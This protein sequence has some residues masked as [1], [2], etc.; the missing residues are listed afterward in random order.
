MSKKEMEKGRCWRKM[1]SVETYMR[2]DEAL[3]PQN[4]QENGFD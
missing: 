3:V 4:L 2:E 1:I